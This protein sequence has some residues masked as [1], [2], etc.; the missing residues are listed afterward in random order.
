MNCL[1]VPVATSPS[2]QSIE[3]SDSP[4]SLFASPSVI[5]RFEIVTESPSAI[6]PRDLALNALNSAH[7]TSVA[8]ADSRQIRYL[9]VP[10]H[11]TRPSSVP[12]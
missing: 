9:P 6:E 11:R 4:M 1:P 5:E 8:G 10:S 3:L 2:T 12:V 7:F